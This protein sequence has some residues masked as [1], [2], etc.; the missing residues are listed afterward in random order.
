M[1]KK[2]NSEESLQQRVKRLERIC[3]FLSI[4][5]LLLGFSGL[6]FVWTTISDLNYV[7]TQTDRIVAQTDTIIAQNNIIREQKAEIKQK[8]A[9]AE[10]GRKNLSEIYRYTFVLYSLVFVDW[11]S[12]LEFPYFMAVYPVVI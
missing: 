8:S 10:E 11:L 2:P 12:M 1:N 4:A 5:I 6:R 7:I 9:D 3:I